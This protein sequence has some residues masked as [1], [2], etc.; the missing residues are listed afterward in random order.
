MRIR[1]ISKTMVAPAP[2]MN[3]RSVASSRPIIRRAWVLLAI[4][5]HPSAVAATTAKTV[6]AVDRKS[7]KAVLL[8]RAPYHTLSDWAPSWA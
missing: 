8:S 6:K 1:P 4:S 5:A 2:A 3:R 7:S